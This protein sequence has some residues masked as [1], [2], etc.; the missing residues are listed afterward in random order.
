MSAGEEPDGGLSELLCALS[1][2][3]DLNTGQPME[4]GLKTAYLSLV[5]AE[6]V[7]LSREDQVTV[8]YGSLLKD[9]G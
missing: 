6:D 7:G 5:L 4:H 3:S 1:F 2:A 9:L 8:F